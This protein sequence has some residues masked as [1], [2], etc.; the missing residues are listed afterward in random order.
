[1]RLA[2]EG[3]KIPLFDGGKAL[4]PPPPWPSGIPARSWG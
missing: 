4:G 3:K 1:M 2:A